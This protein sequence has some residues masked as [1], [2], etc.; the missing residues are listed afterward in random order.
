[1]H[2]RATSINSCGFLLSPCLLLLILAGCASPSSNEANYALREAAQQIDSYE[3]EDV[4]RKGDMIN[5]TL[6]GV[7]SGEGGSFPLKIDESGNI[8]LPHLGNI[9]AAGL[10]SVT[11]KEKIEV[12]Y[13]MGQ[14]Y[15][16]PNVTITSQ[17]ARF[18]TIVGEVRAPQRIYHA[19]DLT[20]LGAIATS[21]GFTD[22]SNRRRVKLLR[23][24]QVIEFDATEILEDP[25]KDIP[26]LPDDK[27]QVD[28][29][30]F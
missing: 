2:P 23:D 14:I 10:N 28:R 13:K 8:S 3:Q 1:M 30:V 4:F 12:L 26:L 5:I 16:N 18:V 19:K 25:T 21:G 22:F 7:P 15:N 20:A 6:N 11:L 24:G 9:R 17:Q 29:S 27:I